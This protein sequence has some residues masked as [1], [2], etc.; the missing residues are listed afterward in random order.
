MKLQ[1]QRLIMAKKHNFKY[2]GDDRGL[3]MLC[4]DVRRRWMQ[5]SDI[6]KAISL[7]MVC[8]I[9]GSVAVEIDHIEPVGSRP[10]VLHELGEYAEKMF[11]SPC[12]ALC[13]KC[14]YEKTQKQRKERRGK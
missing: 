8:V 7:N 13:K 14:H 5:Y 10:L 1:R 12:Q 3:M 6:R 11:Y 2:R 9:C 4:K